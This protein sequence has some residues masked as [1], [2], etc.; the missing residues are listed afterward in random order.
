MQKLLF[1]LKKSK[2]HLEFKPAGL[3]VPRAKIHQIS[4]EKPTVNKKV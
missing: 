3:L 2:S 4:F 1:I